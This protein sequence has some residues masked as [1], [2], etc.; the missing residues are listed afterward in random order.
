MTERSMT[1]FNL[2][3]LDGVVLGNIVLV[4][5]GVETILYSVLLGLES[6]DDAII[7]P[8][9]LSKSIS[10]ITYTVSD[11]DSLIN[12]L[13]DTMLSSLG[14]IVGALLYTLVTLV[15]LGGCVVLDLTSSIDIGIELLRTV[16]VNLGFELGRILADS[17]YVSL[18][19]R[20]DV[21]VVENVVEGEV[22]S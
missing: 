7:L 18:D 6:I 4:V 3:T 21:E 13:F 2:V 16:L 14:N 5:C 22:G 11:I 19:R 1:R 9:I 12:T 20:V 17:G 10:T 15:D 8:Q